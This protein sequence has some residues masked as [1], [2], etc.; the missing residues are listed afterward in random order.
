MIEAKYLTFNEYKQL[1]GN[2]DE[3]A[4]SL[5]E[6]EIEKEI[7]KRTQNRL[8]KLT[9]YPFDLKMCVLKMIDVFEQYKALEQQ[10]KAVTGEGID[11]Y[12]ISYRKL[13]K[14]D[15][16]AKN[17]ELEKIMRRYLSEIIVDGESILFLGV[18]KDVGQF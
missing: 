11:G 7:N 2:L 5:L 14:D 16:E 10:N 17:I 8:V 13:E 9:N 18:N 4:Y 12:S 6:F 1:G 15:I 3:T